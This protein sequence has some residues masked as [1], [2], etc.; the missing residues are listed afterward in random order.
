[1]N[2]PKVYAAIAQ[3]L[4]GLASVGIGKNRSNEAQHYKFR[5]IDDVYN[6]IARELAKAQLVI[7]P[8]CISREQVE[9]QTSKGTALFYTTVMVE[10]DFISAEDGSKHT[11]GPFPGEAMDSADKSTNK[12]MSA[13]YKYMAIETFAIPVNGD[14]GDADSQGHDVAGRTAAQTIALQELRDASLNGMK[15]LETAWNGKPESMRDVLRP[16]LLSLKKAA[17][18]SDKKATEKMATEK[19]AA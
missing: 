1:M 8:R 19:K 9:R 3:V 5:G 16:E 2:T 12:A 11:V 6:A 7:L 15:A 17:A 4:A 10:Y 14:G 13:S 18:E